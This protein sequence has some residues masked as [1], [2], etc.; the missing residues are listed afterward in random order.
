MDWECYLCCWTINL[1][2]GFLVWAVLFQSDFQKKKLY[3]KPENISVQQKSN[4]SRR[5]CNV[6][7]FVFLFSS[8]NQLHFVCNY[9]FNSSHNSIKGRTISRKKIWQQLAWVYEKNTTLLLKNYYWQII[10][11]YWLKIVRVFKWKTHL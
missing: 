3:L 1:I 9:I 8:Y 5:F 11:N 10:T 2:L 7:R 6:C 4:V